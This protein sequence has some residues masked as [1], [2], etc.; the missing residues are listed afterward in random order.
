MGLSV[1][2]E[3]RAVLR[4]REA[5][6]RVLGFDVNDIVSSQQVHQDGVYVV[7][8]GDRGRGATDRKTSIPSKDA[9]ITRESRL[10]LM[11]YFADCVPVFIFDLHCPA[12]GIVHSGR[13]GTLR[14][15]VLRAVEKMNANFGSAPKDCHAAIGPSIRGCCYAVDDRIMDRAMAITDGGLSIHPLANAPGKYSLDLAE[16]NRLLLVK[17]GLPQDHIHDI[18]LCTSCRQDLFYSHQRDVRHIKPRTMV[19]AEGEWARIPSAH[20]PTAESL[21]LQATGRMAGVVWIG[22]ADETGR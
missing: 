12:V 1:G 4:N 21:N 2:D 17:A 6:L 16:V 10:P 14:G 8:K 19:A 13:E 18:G 11:M 5:F 7:L 15:V 20:G 9:L 22:E 3:P